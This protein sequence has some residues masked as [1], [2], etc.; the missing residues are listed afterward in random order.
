MSDTDDL[1]G[2][3]AARHRALAAMSEALDEI[4]V[5]RW[6]VFSLVKIKASLLGIA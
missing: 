2:W 1:G 5:L 6:P 4:H 3:G